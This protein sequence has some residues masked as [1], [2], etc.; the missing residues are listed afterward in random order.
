MLQECTE[1][2]FLIAR[3]AQYRLEDTLGELLASLCKFSSLLNPYA[4]ADETLYG[5]ANDMKP[6][7]ATLAVFAIANSLKESIGGGRRNTADCLLKLK[8]LKLL[9]TGC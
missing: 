9:P 2:L 6:R 7:M 5:F 3:V 1:G 8:R 4:S